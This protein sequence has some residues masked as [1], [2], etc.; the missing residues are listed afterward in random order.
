MYLILKGDDIS[1]TDTENMED[2]HHNITEPDEELRLEA[3]I[4]R[5]R[6]ADPPA[7]PAMD[8]LIEIGEN[9]PIPGIYSQSGLCNFS[10]C[11]KGC[12]GSP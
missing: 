7:P 3:E 6:L 8:P 9:D 2:G 4:V 11:C 10:R 1:I 5:S 12:V